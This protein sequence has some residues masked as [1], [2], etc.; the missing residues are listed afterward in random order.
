MINDLALQLETIKRG[1]VEIYSEEELVGKLKRSIATQ[2][3]LRVKLGIDPTSPDIHLGHTVTLRKLRQFQDL[4]HQAVLIIGNFTALIGDPSGRDKTRP[5][6]TPEQ[7]E[8]NARTYLEQVG[9]ILDLNRTEITK[10]A[11]WLGRLDFHGILKLASQITVARILERDDFSERMKKGTP[12]S[13]HETL[14]PLMQGYDSIAVKADVELGGTDQTF[15]LLTGRDL[16]RNE[17]ME[18]Q[19]AMTT[20]ILPGLDGVQKMS[21]SYG[22]YIGL[23][24]EPNDMFGKVMSI[25]DVLMKDYFVLLTGIPINEIAGLLGPGANP[26][27][28]KVKLAKMIVGQR[29]GE[30][31][32]GDAEE[33]FNRVFSRKELP[34]EIP[35]VLIS[36][37]LMD[38]GKLGLIKLIMHCGFVKSTSDAR[39]LIE[40]GAVTLDNE[41]VLDVKHE[42]EPKNDMILK[43]GK[44]KHFAR[45]KI[46]TKE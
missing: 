46:Q 42:F 32:A 45:L 10:N 9:L 22:N 38:K 29:H 15:N 37:G 6:I 4:G 31:A 43:V 1:V 36:A 40:Q 11:D 39:R 16:Q 35:D 2:K 30:K 7:I 24:D 25:P 14:Y 13:L 18:P 23:K 26:R 21:K 27:D 8:V 41:K 44:K 19:I 33:Y 5:Q 17:G 28:T 20:P 12:I 34:E 3:P